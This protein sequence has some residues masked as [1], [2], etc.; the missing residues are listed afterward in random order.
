MSYPLVQINDNRSI[1]VK[2]GGALTIESNIRS[3]KP[4]PI[5]E[6]Y[7]QFINN[8]IVTRIDSKINGKYID[9]ASLVIKY[10]TTSESGQYTCFA[11]ND[12]GSSKSNSI[13]VN[14]IGGKLYNIKLISC[15]I[16]GKKQKTLKKKS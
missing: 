7:W 1:Q 8:G 5:R 4:Y 11:A 14:V 10:V 15:I 2:Y 3:Y 6:I 9:N 13:D 12:V 16:S